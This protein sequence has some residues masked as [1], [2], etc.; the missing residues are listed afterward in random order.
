MIFVSFLGGFILRLEMLYEITVGL[1]ASLANK[2][3]GSCSIAICSPSE[4][5]KHQRYAKLRRSCN[6]R[7]LLWFRTFRSTKTSEIK[8]KKIKGHMAM[9]RSD[10]QWR[11]PLPVS[12]VH[13]CSLFLEGTNSGKWHLIPCMRGNYSTHSSTQCMKLCKKRPMPHHIEHNKIPAQIR[14]QLNLQQKT[15]M[16]NHPTHNFNQMHN[17]SLILRFSWCNQSVSFPEQEPSF[18]ESFQGILPVTIAGTLTVHTS[19]STAMP[20]MNLRAEFGA[21]PVIANLH[22]KWYLVET[23]I[24]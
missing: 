15:C 21:T 24:F 16:L 12:P 10:H 19:W 22:F 18:D 7:S 6:C 13:F 4:I 14:K 17:K 11:L 2:G 5:F 1:Y 3:V 23:F 9:T 20:N 8:I